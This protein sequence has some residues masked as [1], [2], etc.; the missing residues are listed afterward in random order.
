MLKAKHNFFLIPFFRWYTVWI[1]ERHFRTI[2]ILGKIPERNLPVLVLS[3]HVTW[4][5]GFWVEYLNVKIFGRKFHFMMLEEMLRKHR[6]FNYIGG[7][8]VDKKSRSIIDSLNYTSELISDNRNT[9]L[10]FPQG[11][12]QSTYN[13]DFIFETGINRIL[14]D[15]QGKVQVVLL[16]CM[17]DYFTHKEPSLYMHVEEYLLPNL[18]SASL[19]KEYN[20]FYKRCVETQKQLID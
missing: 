20:E 5:D 17:V 12:I 10:V 7:Y 8:S 1:I 3:N 9:V 6:F 19:E 18:D 2:Q 16:A 11:S 4:W 13:Q 14:K 15:K